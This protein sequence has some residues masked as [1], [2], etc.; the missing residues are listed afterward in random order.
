MESRSFRT[1][2][3][4]PITGHCHPDELCYHLLEAEKLYCYGIQVTMFYVDDILKQNKT[5]CIC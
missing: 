3:K 5:Q 2:I 1:S 4:N